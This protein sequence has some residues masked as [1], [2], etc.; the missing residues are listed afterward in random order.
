MLK[1]LFSRLEQFRVDKPGLPVTGRVVSVDALRGFDMFWIIGGEAV[2]RTFERIYFS[3]DNGFISRQLTHVEWT[4]FRFYDIIMPLFLFIVGVAMPFSFRKRLEKVPSKAA[5]WPHII[6][7]VIV[8]W[9]LGM[10]VQGNLLDYDWD[11]IKF[12]SNT[13]QAIACGY[14]IAS[15]LMLYCRISWQIAGTVILMFI[16][17]ALLAFASVPGFGPGV[18]TP[19]GN[20]AIYI[21]KLILGKFQDGTTYSW[22]VSS[23]NFGATVMLGVFSGYLLQSGLKT[24]KKI[25][26]LIIAGVALIILGKVWGIWLPSVKHIWTSSFV[27]FSGGLCILLL[28]LFMFLVDKLDLKKGFLFF[29]IIGM[30]AIFAYCASHLFDFGQVADVFVGGLKDCTGA[31][32]YFLRALGGFGVLYFILWLMYKYRIFIKI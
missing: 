18:I 27:L 9:I 24:G 26:S 28:A 31:W 4:G 32:Y 21:D 10:A 15:L 12:F 25:T 30:N 13:L 29:T 5:M 11:K 16:Y 19:D 23:L 3:G 22:I 17:W 7:R 20:F 6:K 2:F 1:E 8:L 14:L